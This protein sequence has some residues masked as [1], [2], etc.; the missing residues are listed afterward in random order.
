MVA[1]G[2]THTGVR[3]KPQEKLQSERERERE[4]ERKPG[5]IFSKKHLVLLNFNGNTM[6]N[7]IS[8]V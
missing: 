7:G 4:R 6:N 2:T 1:K 5:Y 3:G 8:G